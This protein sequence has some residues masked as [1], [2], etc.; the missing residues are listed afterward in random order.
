MR[1]KHPFSP[2]RLKKAFLHAFDGVKYVLLTE[3]NM[4]VHLVMAAIA[5]L[6]SLVLRI[7]TFEWIFILMAIFGV[8]TLEFLNSAIE[9]VVD[10]ITNE[11]HPLAKQAKDIAAAA[12]LISSFLSVIIGCIIFIPKIIESLF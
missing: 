5:L 9:R 2:K 4:V 3:K 8:I 11:Y 6:M 12:V 10:L 7:N 1:G